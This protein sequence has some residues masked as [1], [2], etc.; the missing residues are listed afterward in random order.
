M[1]RARDRKTRDF[2]QVKCIKD[3][4]EQ[5]LVKEED[6]RHRSNKMHEECR[7]S[8]LVPIYKDKGVSKVVLIIG[9]L[10]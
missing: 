8:I 4:R 9:E 1:A 2:N 5:L 7:R 6:I 10:S 3:E